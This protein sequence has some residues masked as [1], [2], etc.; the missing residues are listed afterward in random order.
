LASQQTAPQLS[1]AL[2]SLGS[3]AMDSPHVYDKAKYH[4][5]TVEEHG[6]SEVHAANHT[7][8]FLRW[9]I[10]NNLMSQEF[11]DETG[12]EIEKFRAGE[13]TIHEVYEWWDCCLFDE[14]LSEEGNSFAMHYFDFA[15]GKHIH[16]Y[17]ELLQGGLPSEFH[18][19]YNE[20]NYQR[21]KAVID[22]RFKQWKAP[23][24]RWWPF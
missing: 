17:I 7:V 8:F 6:L 15:K 11:M 21:M 18:I 9:L 12:G 5:E 19:D 14:M 20:A 1:T 23:K 3:Q 24:K 13:A 4:Y 22:R 10:E 16:D 2:D